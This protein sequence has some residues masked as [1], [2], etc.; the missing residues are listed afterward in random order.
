MSDR[1]L[2]RAAA[3]AAGY[4]GIIHH[5]G[6]IG[7]MVPCGPPGCSKFEPWNPYEEDGAAFLA[8]QQLAT[9]PSA[10][11]PE[12]SDAERLEFCDVRNVVLRSDG[13]SWV[14]E[15][16]LLDLPDHEEVF[17]ADTPNAA[18]DAAIRATKG[19]KL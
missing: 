14:A 5:D 8:G 19:G 12:P 3:K 7:V 4:S 16:P 18:I 9:P 15:V 10:A 2:L 17:A 11:T 1:E 6:R 13:A